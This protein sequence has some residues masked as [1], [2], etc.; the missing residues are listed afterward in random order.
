MVL[1]FDRVSRVLLTRRLFSS[2]A[3]RSKGAERVRLLTPTKPLKEEPIAR[4]CPGRDHPVKLGDIYNDRY[5]VLRK[6]GWGACSTV[7]LAKDAKMNRHIALKIMSAD[8]C[9]Y[10][11]EDYRWQ[12]RQTT[13]EREILQDIDKIKSDHPGRKYLPRLLDHF[14]H[15]GPHGTHPCLV[16]PLMGRSLDPFA[17]QW[18]PPRIPSPI[19]RQISV[20][21]L[22][23]LDFLHHIKPMNILLDLKYADMEE[24]QREYAVRVLFKHLPVATGIAYPTF[25]YVESREIYMPIQHSGAVQIQIADLGSA[26]WQDRHLSP[27]IQPKL[28]RAPEVYLFQP[29]SQSV[30][31]WNAGAVLWEL[32]T[33]SLLFSGDPPHILAQM[34]ALVGSFPPEFI[35][36]CF[37]K[38]A[39]RYGGITLERALAD[40]P[41]EEFPMSEEERRDWL[42]FLRSM[43]KI[44]P[45]ERKTAKELLKDPWLHKEYEYPTYECDM[46]VHGLPDVMPVEER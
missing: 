7:W 18:K 16:F 42:A 46:F 8:A 1:L 11:D 44:N 23:A 40:K 13:F 6:L 10:Y 9:G 15:I 24:D 38:N 2:L 22:S 12:A 3:W 37:I 30:D 14:E 35:S 26:C 32:M 31:I 45:V 43:L 28:L 17:A 41:E 29:W 39:P 27:I 36:S 21:I 25:D 20:Q 19:M 34:A 4:Y 5:E 33:A